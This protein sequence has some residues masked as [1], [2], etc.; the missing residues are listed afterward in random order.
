MIDEDPNVA[1]D[2]LKE[3]ELAGI[4][5]DGYMQW[6]EE[7]G[8]DSD[9]EVYGAEEKIEVPLGDTGFILRGKLDARALRRSTGA[10]VF[11]EHKTVSNMVDLKKSAQ[12]NPQFLG[13]ELLE[14]LSLRETGRD[15]ERADGTLLNMLKKVKRTAR[16]KPPFYERHEVHHNLEELRNHQRHIVSI[17]REIEA[18]RG[19]LDAGEPHHAVC[20]P[21]SSG[22]RPQCTWCS[23][24]DVCLSGMFDDG[25]DIESYLGMFYEPHDP[26]SYY[27]EEE[28]DE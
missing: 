4:M 19:R 21:S 3:A 8:A 7:T 17:G 5:L 26:Y 20:P 15:G 6:V 24:K 1:D 14:F 18:A 12:T 2:I 13:Y 22:A 27:E 23:Y 10:R 11:L 9:L 16:A 28:E 25:S